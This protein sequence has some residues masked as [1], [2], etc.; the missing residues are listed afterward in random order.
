MELSAA[1]IDAA[2][3]KLNQY[4]RKLENAGDEIARR[5]AQLGYQT[6]YLIMSEHIYSGETI[7]S[8]TVDEL[9]NGKYVLKANSE[10][11]LFFEFG[12]G[13]NGVGHPLGMGVGTYPGQKH[14]F[15]PNG[16]WFLTDDPNL[17]VRKSKDGKM[18]G[19]S[20]GNP[21]YMPFYLASRE[22]RDELLNVAKEVMQH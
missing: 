11:L 7:T 12:A 8:L 19:H 3:E 17:A 13:V 1:S 18:W 16:W 14:A 20:Y 5:L 15:D 10:A 21:P 2:I 9:G 6:A 22:I 4:K